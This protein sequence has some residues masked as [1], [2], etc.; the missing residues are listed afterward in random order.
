VPG[1]AS[2]DASKHGCPLPPPPPADTDGDGITDDLD[3]C[4]SEPG[5]HHAD[6]KKNGCPVGALVA[7]ELVLDN[8]RRY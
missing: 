8:V 3:A 5:P 1:V 2:D 6:A 7:G 4:P